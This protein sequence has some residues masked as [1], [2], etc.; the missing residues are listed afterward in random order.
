MIRKPEE[1]WSR[2]E[3]HSIVQA[4]GD[5]RVKEDGVFSRK[6]RWNSEGVGMVGEAV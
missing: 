3:D 1:G 6:T 5:K 2:I 4:G